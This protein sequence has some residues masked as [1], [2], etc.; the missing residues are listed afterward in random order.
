[1]VATLSPVAII[2]AF[3]T[4]LRY[5]NTHTAPAGR[6]FKKLWLLIDR[7]QSKALTPVWHILTLLPLL[8]FVLPS[9]SSL[10]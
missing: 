2:L 4:A 6:T 9:T 10:S 3:G 8:L 7:A 1:M 5:R